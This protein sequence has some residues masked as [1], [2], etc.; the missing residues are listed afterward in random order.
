MN[1]DEKIRAYHQ[2]NKEV[3]I[4]CNHR[5][6]IILTVRFRKRA[7]IKDQN[8]G[9][10][11]VSKKAEEVAGLYAMMLGYSCVSRARFKNNFFKDWT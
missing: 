4:M 7:Q 10:V 6:A 3:A 5:R 9:N 2:A 8:P 11:E 1:L